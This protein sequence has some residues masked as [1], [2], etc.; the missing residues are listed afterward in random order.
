LSK[1]TTGDTG[2]IG[3]GFMEDRFSIAY[4]QA[5]PRDPRVPRGLLFLNT[6]LKNALVSRALRISHP[7]ALF[8]FDET[9]FDF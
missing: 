4:N 2:K 6:Q 9:R 7:A 1:K 3:K 8:S 5:Y